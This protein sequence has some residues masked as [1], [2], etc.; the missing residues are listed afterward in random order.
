MRV[1][2]LALF[3]FIGGKG[4]SQ[5]SEYTVYEVGKGE[6]LKNKYFFLDYYGGN[7]LI[8]VPLRDGVDYTNVNLAGIIDLEEKIR[9]PF[10][11]RN[12]EK[13]RD[14]YN[15]YKGEI[16]LLAISN[17]KSRALYR[18]G[19]VDF[20]PITDFKYWKFRPYLFD[21]NYVMAYTGFGHIVNIE[22]KE[23]TTTGFEELVPLTKEVIAAKDMMRNWSVLTKKGD[24]LLPKEF[25]RIQ[26]LSKQFIIIQKRDS[27]GVLD[28]SGR[29]L[30]PP[31]YKN[32]QLSDTRM[33]VTSFDKIEQAPLDSK[34]QEYIAVLDSVLDSTLAKEEDKCYKPL[35]STFN[36]SRRMDDHYVHGAFDFQG[37]LKIPFDYDWLEKGIA[38]EIIANKNGRFG[39]L[40]EK[41][42]V[43]VDFEY[44]DITVLFDSFYLV[45]KENKQG[46]FTK[47]N[48]KVLEVKYEEIFPISNTQVLFVENGDWYQVEYSANFKEHTVR[49]TKLHSNFGF[50][51]MDTF[52]PSTATYV[53]NTDFFVLYNC[54]ETGIIDKNLNI[55]IP[56]EHTQ[57]PRYFNEKHFDFGVKYTVKGVALKDMDLSQDDVDFK[58]TIIGKK[59][60]KYGVINQD[61]TIL[62]PFQYS[63][64]QNIDG[65]R[66]VVKR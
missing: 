20:E 46:L 40:S 32:I 59:E 52:E 19:K 8:A 39:V 41:G 37:K 5:Q 15:L 10:Q 7:L 42:K 24:T 31:I 34:Q 6:I 12:I 44:E 11:Y 54:S 27:M 62:V 35:I 43:L 47:K 33:L 28:A 45:K 23:I 21:G 13:V 30:L 53:K 60:G 16:P 36:H 4:F 2:I 58:E 55:I 48:K 56:C 66:F 64:I 29:L 26:T 1:F 49:K 61:G 51:Y 22:T 50:A 38:N 25:D 9:L 18:L 65:K 17:G 57:I 14:G 63:S 3:L